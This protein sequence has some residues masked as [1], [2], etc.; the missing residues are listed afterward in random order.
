MSDEF[1]VQWSVSLP[2]AA[3]YAKG[4]MLNIRGESVADVEAM[5]DEILSDPSEFLQK[6]ASVATTLRAASVVTEGLEGV[7]RAV[8]E[9]PVTPTGTTQTPAPVAELHACPHGKRTYKTGK[10][11]NGSQWAA[12]FCPAPKGAPDQC[13]PDWVG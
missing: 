3:Q 13:A 6:A 4:D 12:W 9:A 11:A 1:K 2:P 7:S 5:F 8:S 10:K